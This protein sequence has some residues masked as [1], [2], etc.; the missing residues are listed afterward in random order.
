MS[1]SIIKTPG[2]MELPPS[3]TEVSCM[4]V[5]YSPDYSCHENYVKISARNKK[6]LEGMGKC[7]ILVKTTFVEGGTIVYIF[8]F[9]TNEGLLAFSLL[10]FTNFD[11]RQFLESATEYGDKYFFSL[12]PSLL[13]KK[14]ICC[15]TIEYYAPGDNDIKEF[16]YPIKKMIKIGSSEANNLFAKYSNPNNNCDY[17]DISK[18]LLDIKSFC[19]ILNE[20]YANPGY[21]N[22]LTFI[23]ALSHDGEYYKADSS[24][25]VM[26][27]YDDANNNTLLEK[28]QQSAFDVLLDVVVPHDLEYY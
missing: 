22:Y 16:C 1:T 18:F 12:F 21:N 7:Y 4:F 11:T 15:G 26:F 5:P 6:R 25:F 23:D 28:I 27:E 17:S 9:P 14:E 3:I 2:N 8:V 13:E 24:S 19:D 20:C 10:Y